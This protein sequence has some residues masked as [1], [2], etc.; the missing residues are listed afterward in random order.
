MSS[1]DNEQLAPRS[2]RKTRPEELTSGEI[3]WKSHYEWLLEAGYR[4]RSRYSPDW[5]P[6]WTGTKRD[7]LLCEDSEKSLSS[8]VNHATSLKEDAFVVLKRIDV[9]KYPKEVEITTY[10]TTEPL[11]SQAENHTIPLIEV[12][13]PP[14]E[15]DVRILVLPLLRD[16]DDPLFETMGEAI[17]FLD[18]FLEA[19]TFLHK[20]RV[21]HGDIS[22]NNV[23]MDGKEMYPQDFHP[24]QHQMKK[25]YSGLVK[26]KYSRTE[27][28]PKY[29]I[30]DFG[31]S[32]RF[33]LDEEPEALDTVGTDTTVPEYRNEYPIDPFFVDVYCVGNMLRQ[34]FLDG[35]P[36]RHSRKGY[37]GFEFLRP[38]ITDMTQD[39]PSKRPSM[40]EALKRFRELVEAFTS[41][42]LRSPC[43]KVL[44]Y[45]GQ[46]GSPPVVLAKNVY[47]WCKSVTYILRRLPPIPQ[48]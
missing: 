10:L 5:K 38:L 19:V 44:S 32:R 6:S 23:M 18:Q 36:S 12:L 4:L 21:V 8:A 27:K 31:L 3:Y 47:H 35:D 9:S 33:E 29:Y 34:E 25:D 15:E 41:M 43:R 45:K 26:N 37:Y 1:E 7:P 42:Q 11:K 14:Q 13:Q 48:S 20:N 40:E 2:T 46:D 17:H 28:A 24:V 22:I 30:L 39:D 16:Y